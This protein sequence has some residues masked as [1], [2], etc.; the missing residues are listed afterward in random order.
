MEGIGVGER[1]KICFLGYKKLG[2]MAHRV[3]AGLEYEDTV[4]LEKECTPVTMEQAV[5]EARNEGCQVFIAGSANAAEFK[6]RFYEHLIELHIDLA[7]YLLSLKRAREQG[8]ERVAIV[9]HR[10]SRKLDVGLLQGLTD[11]PLQLVYYEDAAKPQPFSPCPTAALRYPGSMSRLPKEPNKYTGGK[12]K[13]ITQ[14]NLCGCTMNGRAS[15]K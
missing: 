2:E 12:R 15:W 14:R 9:V 3:I 13:W 11:M 4:I 10:Q 7:D 5:S 1:Y 8:A 6:R